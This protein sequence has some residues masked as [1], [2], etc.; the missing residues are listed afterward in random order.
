MS[1]A[2]KHKSLLYK[3]T[4]SAVVTFKGPPPMKGLCPQQPK[5]WNSGEHSPFRENRRFW[6][7][8]SGRECRTSTPCNF[9]LIIRICPGDHLLPGF[10]GF[11]LSSLN[12][13][14]GQ[15][16]PKAT[17]FYWKRWLDIW[18]ILFLTH[19][20]G[21]SKC[22]LCRKSVYFTKSLK[23]LMRM[24]KDQRDWDPKINEWDE[25]WHIS[26]FCS[27]AWLVLG[28]LS[29]LLPPNVLG[30]ATVTM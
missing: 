27:V 21:K 18:R 8:S 1:I 12:R 4:E 28:I 9:K 22:C 17:H 5:L 23:M 16:S 14:L 19:V 13:Q 24:Y 11:H 15:M 10:P 26:W 6:G 20:H 29:S 3:R 7:D 25:S 2:P 30:K